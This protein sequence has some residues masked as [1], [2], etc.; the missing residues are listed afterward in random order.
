MPLPITTSRA[1]LPI[2]RLLSIACLQSKCAASVMSKTVGEVD[3]RAFLLNQKE[4]ARSSTAP[5]A[6]E[7]LR[8]YKN[9][10]YRN[11]KRH[12]CRDPEEP[13][14]SRLNKPTLSLRHSCARDIARA[15]GL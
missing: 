9:V 4:Y 11:P 3:D 1:L 5:T 8:R 6:F 14:Q 13:T 15:T 7:R 10:R 12:Q 2:T